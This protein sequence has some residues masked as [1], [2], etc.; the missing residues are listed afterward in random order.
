MR[1]SRTRSPA[2]CES[3]LSRRSGP[4]EDLRAAARRCDLVEKRKRVERARGRL[5]VEL[6]A[7]EVLSREPFAGAVVQR[8]VAHVLICEYRE[9]VVLHGHENAACLRIADR[10]VRAAVAERQLERLV[11]ECEAEQLVAETDAEE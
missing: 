3:G 7:R 9:A 5:G 6:H 10:M 1:S 11:P 8:H 2:R 4:S